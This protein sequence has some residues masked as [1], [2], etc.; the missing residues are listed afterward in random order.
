[1]SMRQEILT[2]LHASHLGYVRTKQRARQTVFWP[3]I[4]REIEDV[5]R[6]CDRCQRDL[7]SHAYEPLFTNKG[8]TK[9]E[10]NEEWHADLFEQ[11]GQFLVVVDRALGYPWI[12]RWENSPTTSK[13]IAAILPWMTD[14]G[15]PKRLRSDGGPQF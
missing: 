15:I 12:K 3:G 9:I 10:A 5:I 11:D 14:F 4:T 2:K 6:R 13:V 8:E 7:P 1:M